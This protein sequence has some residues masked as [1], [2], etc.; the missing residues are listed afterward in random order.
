M[1]SNDNGYDLTIVNSNVNVAEAEDDEEILG[2]EIYDLLGRR[3]EEGELTPGIY[4]VRYHTNKGV[5]VEKML[6][7]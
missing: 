2:V 4:I 5:R 7:Q 1:I 6:K 3:M